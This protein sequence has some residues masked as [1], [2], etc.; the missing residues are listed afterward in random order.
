MTAEHWLPLVQSL[1]LLLLAGTSTWMG[2]GTIRSLRDLRREVRRMS[3]IVD[4]AP[5]GTCKRHEDVP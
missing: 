2:I 5:G 1:A 4:A 3:T